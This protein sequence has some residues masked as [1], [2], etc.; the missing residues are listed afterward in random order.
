[1]RHGFIFLPSLKRR[2][3]V[4]SRPGEP[5]CDHLAQDE[6]GAHEHAPDEKEEGKGHRVEAQLLGRHDRKVLQAL[7]WK[8]NF[9]GLLIKSSTS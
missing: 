1:M 5:D 6:R 3:V 7:V 2:Q 4:P 8:D 9:L